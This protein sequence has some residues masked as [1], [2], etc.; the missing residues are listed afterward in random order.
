MFK[1]L[2]QPIL[3]R[4]ILSFLLNPSV[5]EQ[6]CRVYLDGTVGEGGHSEEILRATAPNGFLIGLDRDE[7]AISRVGERLKVHSERVL[8]MTTSYGNILNILPEISKKIAE[9]KRVLS[10]G[11]PSSCVLDERS[12]GEDP[13]PPVFF[14]WL[15]GILLDLGLSSRQLSEG[16]RG[17]SFKEEG[18]LDM[19][20]DR[21]TRLTAGEIVN[22]WPE[23]KIEAILIEFGEESWAKKIASAIIVQRRK[24]R[25]ETTT[26]L[27]GLIKQVIPFRFQSKIH[28]ATKTFQALRIAVN[29]ELKELTTFL[30]A[31]PTLA[32]RFLKKRARIAILSFHSLEDRL[33]KT[34]FRKGQSEGFLEILTKKPIVPTEEEIAENPRARSTHLRVAEVIQ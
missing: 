7:V 23:K 16:E 29:D 31:L 3:C 5:P 25:F 10:T 13:S 6:G 9:K 33:V 24:K 15:D 4:E 20:F 2:H 32:E 18:P 28:P 8:L 14:P 11:I 27:A 30:E 21:S 34:A 22:R 1:P 17:F 26:E 19:R 12:R